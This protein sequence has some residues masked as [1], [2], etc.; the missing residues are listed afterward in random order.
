MKEVTDALTD[1]ANHGNFDE[2]SAARM[3]RDAGIGDDVIKDWLAS[4]K[5]RAQE[6]NASGNGDWNFGQVYRDRDYKVTYPLTNNCKVGRVVTITYPNTLTLSGPAEVAV[7]PKSTVDVPMTL[8]MKDPPIPPPPWPVGTRFDC[9]DIEGKITFVHEKLEREEHTADGDLTY[10]CYEMERTHRITM[11][12]HQHAPPG[13]PEGGGGGGGKKKKA[14]PACDLLWRHDEFYPDAT[15]RQPNDCRDEIR[16]LAI[17]FVEEQVQP[18]SA[19]DRDKLKWAWVPNRVQLAKMAVD[20]LL[21]MKKRA[22][23][24]AIAP[25]K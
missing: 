22:D 18:L 10:V 16:D 20:D 24:L 3:M 2:A 14:S 17:D 23:M 7:P 25:K 9:Y 15:K 6:Q 8:K 19:A 1:A 5:K 13:P 12:V 11:H 4:L 21:E